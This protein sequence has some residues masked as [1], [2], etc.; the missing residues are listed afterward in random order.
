LAKGEQR[1]EPRGFGEVDKQRAAV[2]GVGEF[3]LE[4][5]GEDQDD[6]RGFVGDFGQ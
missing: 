4:I 5:R 6:G 3:V 1:A 2:D